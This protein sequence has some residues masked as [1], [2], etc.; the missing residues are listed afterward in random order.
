[1]QDYGSGRRCGVEL[2]DG[3][4]LVRGGGDTAGT[5]AAA[6]SAAADPAADEHLLDADFEED[7]EPVILTPVPFPTPPAAT[8]SSPQRSPEKVNDNDNSV[9][10]E[11]TDEKYYPFSGG[12][13][14]EFT[15]QSNITSYSRYGIRFKP[16]TGDDQRGRL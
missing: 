12:S 9:M 14:L 8:G 10:L 4:R 1:M 7:D 15:D 3:V 2:T 6:P 5:D 16:K 11:S 13:D